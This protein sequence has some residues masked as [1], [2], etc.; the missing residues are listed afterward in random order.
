V[1]SIAE[2]TEKLSGNGAASKKFVLLKSKERGRKVNKSEKGERK[3]KTKKYS[4]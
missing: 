4:M 3:P 2:G 1:E